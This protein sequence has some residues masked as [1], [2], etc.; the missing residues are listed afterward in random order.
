M[1]GPCAGDVVLGLR[2]G[3]LRETLDAFRAC[4]VR[5]DESVALLVLGR[6]RL[7]AG[8]NTAPDAVEMVEVRLVVGRVAAAAAVVSGLVEETVEE[9]REGVGGGAERLSRNL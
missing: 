8:S 2:C 7:V 1:V 3:W 4:S 5:R 6:R 9:G